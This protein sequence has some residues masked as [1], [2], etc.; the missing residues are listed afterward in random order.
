MHSMSEGQFWAVSFFTL[1][2]F[3]W[4]LWLP[5]LWEWFRDLVKGGARRLFRLIRDELGLLRDACRK[6]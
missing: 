6:D 4:E 2:V 3:T 1:A 5:P